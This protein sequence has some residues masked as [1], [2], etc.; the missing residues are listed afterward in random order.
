VPARRGSCI[1]SSVAALSLLEEVFQDANKAVPARRL[2]PRA[3]AVQVRRLEA[4]TWVDVLPCTVLYIGV[5]VGPSLARRPCGLASI[6]LVA[7]RRAQETPRTAP[8][9]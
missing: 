7:A 8:E 4:P 1:A 2:C 3:S 9:P 5:S 6:S